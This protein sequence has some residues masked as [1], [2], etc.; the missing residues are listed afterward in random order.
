M[1]VPLAG[2]RVLG[3]VWGPGSGG[4]PL[5]KLKSII[6][7]KPLKGLSADI[8]NLVDWVGEYYVVPSGAALRMVLSA[9]A[10]LREPK[11]TK[12]YKDAG[13][14][15]ARLTPQRT[16]VF[17]TLG[18][19]LPRVLSDIVIDAQVGPGVVQHLEAEGHLLVSYV[20]FPP[21]AEVPNPEH[22]APKLSATQELAANSLRRAVKASRFKV[23]LLDGVT[24]A[25]KTEVYFEA[26]SAALKLGYQILI[27]VPEVALTE[28]WIRRFEARFGV[29]PW[30]WHSGIGSAS[31]RENWRRAHSSTGGVFVGTRSALFLPFQNLGLIVVDEEHDPSYKQEEGVFYNARDAAVMRGS[32]ASCLVVL[33]SATPSLETH[34]NVNTGRYDKL[35]LA[36]RFGGSSLPAIDAVDMRRNKPAPGRWISPNLDNAVRETISEGSQALLFLNR[37][38]YAPL[39]LCGSCGYR[40]E[41]QSCS[42]WLVEHRDRSILSCHHCGHEEKRPEC[43]PKC[44]AEEAMVACGPGVE[45]LAEEVSKFIPEARVRLM[46]SDTITSAR[47][48]V[49]LVQEMLVGEIDVL[50]GTQMVTKGFHFP[51]LTLVGVVDA[52]LGLSGGNLR[53]GE[54]SMQLLSQVAGRAGREQ[55]SGRAILQTYLPEHPVMDA[56]IRGDRDMFVTEEIEARREAKM[57]PF[58]RL[59]GLIISSASR[60]LASDTARA[61]AKKVPQV[62]GLEVFGPAPAPISLLRGKYRFRLLVRAPRKFGLQKVLHYWLA[63]VKC[64]KTVIVRVDVDPYNFM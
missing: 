50:I 13:S 4:F 34:H 40:V 64:P 10:A 29:R 59:A 14:R 19:G 61:L 41:C 44:G 38:G 45:R 32:F 57:P 16:R 15:P 33:V 30:A 35:V 3:V 12:L 43:C 51:S 25:G 24:G 54:R 48:A 1:D 31:R 52:D 55:K 18:D 6:S 21:K 27:L 20:H 22:F 47:Q 62:A 7:R 42:A 53:A 37:R 28:D 9:P 39:T 23:N 5:S 8:R 58:A 63:Q 56:L 2:R 11:P 60:K 26:I 36:Q 49:E 17:Q 46:T